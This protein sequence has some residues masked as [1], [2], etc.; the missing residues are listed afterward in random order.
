MTFM[1]SEM[2]RFWELGEKTWPDL[3]NPLKRSL[4][5]ISMLSITIV[6]VGWR[7]LRSRENAE[8]IIVIQILKMKVI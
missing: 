2:G 7:G 5:A 8:T 6:W 4:A 3:T 1:L